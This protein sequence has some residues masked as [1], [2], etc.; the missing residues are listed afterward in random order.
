MTSEVQEK[1]VTA[2]KRG[3]PTA[4]GIFA[5]GMSLMALSFYALGI[6]PISS[7]IVMLVPAI[8]FGGLFLLIASI[9][10]YVNGNTFG[11]TAFGCY[12]AFFL[13]F[14]FVHVGLKLGWFEDLAVAHLVGIFC[15]ALAYITLVLWIG[16]FKM[17]LALNLTL[18]FLLLVFIFFFIPLMTRDASG[19]TAM[20][21]WPGCLITA[22]VF[23]MIDTAFTAWVGIAVV[24]NDRWERV[25]K[26]GPIPLFPIGQPK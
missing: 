15:L 11:A 16:S 14:G 6:Y 12:S 9:W 3:D 5:Y 7:L 21:A 8:F 23:G 24:V 13:T 4:L 18:F 20:G 2:S 25:G 26:K 22:G 17:N 10:E 1:G 19:H